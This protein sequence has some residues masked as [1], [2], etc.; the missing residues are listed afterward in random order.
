[1]MKFVIYIYVEEK[2]LKLEKSLGLYGIV[3]KKSKNMFYELLRPFMT[4]HQEVTFKKGQM[5]YQE[6]EIPKELYLIENGIVGLFSIG[7]NGKETFLRVFNTK[8]IFGHRSY[9]AQTN[10]HATAIALVDTTVTV[11]S[12]DQCDQLCSERP[13]LLKEITRML[14]VDL[15]EAEL[16]LAGLFVKSANKRIVE[17]LIY[18]KLKYPEKI[19]TRKEIAEYSGSTFET[20][21][22]VMSILSKEKLI[23]KN[24]RDFDIYSLD[25]LLEY[26]SKNF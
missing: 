3:F 7:Q 19:W 15:G 12:K 16:R 23:E 11:I 4:N 10:Y 25:E 2:I 18:F 24:K 17:S 20:V 21:A 13:E 26:S 22:R 14:A 8:S 6:G 9:L 1:M 5:I